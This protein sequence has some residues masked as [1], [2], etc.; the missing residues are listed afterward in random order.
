MPRRFRAVGPLAIAVVLV[1]L[2]VYTLTRVLE[3]GFRG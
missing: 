2:N 1:A 3:P